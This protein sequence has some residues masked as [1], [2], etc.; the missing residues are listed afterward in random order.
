MGFTG[1]GVLGRVG[2]SEV[3][4]GLTGVHRGVESRLQPLSL[5]G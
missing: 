2:G 4:G 3:G 1:G 5:G